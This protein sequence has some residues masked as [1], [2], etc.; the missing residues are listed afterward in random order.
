MSFYRQWAAAG[1]NKRIPMCST[2]LGAGNEQSVLTKAEGLLWDRSALYA[3]R[4]GKPREELLV[5]LLETFDR[6]ERLGR[7]AGLVMGVSLVQ[8]GLLRQRGAGRAAFEL[9]K[10][11][12]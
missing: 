11:G 10:Q 2:T 6:G 1:M 4:T 5:Q 3:T 8:L 9:A 7:L 12:H